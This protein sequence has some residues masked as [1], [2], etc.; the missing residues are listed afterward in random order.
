MVYVD[1]LIVSGESF[2][3]QRFF[4]EIQNVFSLKQIDYLT[5][6]HPVE[7]LDRIIKKRRSAQITME[8]SPTFIDTC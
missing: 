3:A 7:F 1:D 5:S 4:Q 6:K 2:S 8:F